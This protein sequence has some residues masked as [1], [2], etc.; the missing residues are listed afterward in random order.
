MPHQI[1][2]FIMGYPYDTQMSVERQPAYVP[3]IHLGEVYNKVYVLGSLSEGQINDILKVSQ[4]SSMAS[5]LD[6]LCNFGIDM[7][8]YPGE[9]FQYLF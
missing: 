4:L 3:A 6:I 1:V 8:K 9:M 5:T 2:S 7:A